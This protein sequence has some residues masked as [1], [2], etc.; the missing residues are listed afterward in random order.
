MTTMKRLTHPEALAHLDKR[1]IDTFGVGYVEYDAGIAASLVPTAYLSAA[2]RLTDNSGIIEKLTKWDSERRKSNA[3]KKALIPLRALVVLY[4]LNTQMGLGVTYKELARTLAHRFAPKHFA[5]LGIGVTSSDTLHWYKRV[6]DTTYRLIELMNPRPATLNKTL[7]A[8]EY[9]ELLITSAVPSS[10]ALAMRNQDRLDTFCRLLVEA[11]YR[12][13]PDDV[14]Q[15]YRGNIAIDATKTQIRGRRNS[16]SKLGSRSNP[17]AHAGRYMREGSHGG[18]GAATDEAA[19][20][21]ETAVMIW[22][23]PGENAMFPSLITE[24]SCH[25]PGEFVGHAANLTAHHQRLGFNQVT[26]IVDR[27]YNYERIETFHLPMARLGVELVFDYK[28]EDLGLQSHFSDLILVDGSWYVNWMPKSLIEASRKVA[29]T[30]AARDEAKIVVYKTEHP[31]K[32]KGPSFE[33]VQTAMRNLT[34]SEEAL[35]NLQRNIDAREP[36]NGQSELPIGG[37]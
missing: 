2:I 34:D 5:A 16:A 25:N 8:K 36:V 7:N 14:R 27:A 9:E 17:D 37:Q 11:S 3:G 13:L 28:A 15:R 20:E 19:Y 1:M 22:N 26:A 10:Q 30:E 12:H 29:A 33:D 35:P 31:T 23:K 32:R 4:L 24:I 21:L 6:S 18:A